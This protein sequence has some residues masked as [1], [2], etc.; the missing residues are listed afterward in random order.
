MLRRAL[1][2]SLATAALG[3]SATAASATTIK[4]LAGATVAPGSSVTGG[5]KAGTTWHLEGGSAG[6]VD[7]GTFTIGGMLA[8]NPF[9]PSVT[10]SASSLTF[11]NCSDTIPFVTVST[12]TTNVGTGANA[13]SMMFTYVPPGTSSSLMVA[14]LGFTI[15]FSSG[16][17]CV[18][19]PTGGAAT[20]T[21]NSNTTPWNNEYAFNNVPYTKTGGTFFACPSSNVTVSWTWVLTSGGAGITIQP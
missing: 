19:E 6:D 13:K 10:G 3:S 8:T 4:T 17:T 14:G 1:I 2:L 9:T 21:H 20:G 12:I 16:S 15:T 18:Y 5:L 11:A 7:C